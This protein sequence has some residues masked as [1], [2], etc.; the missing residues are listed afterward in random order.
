MAIIAQTAQVTVEAWQTSSDSKGGYYTVKVSRRGDYF[1]GGAVWRNSTTRDRGACHVEIEGKNVV[2]WA[3]PHISAWKW[4]GSVYY[5]RD[6]TS[7]QNKVLDWMFWA[8]QPGWDTF[9]YREFP[10]NRVDINRGTSRQ[11]S[12]SVSAG[13]VMENG[14]SS[15]MGSITIYTS[16]IAD[17]SNVGLSA[18]VSSKTE[19]KRKITV[20]CSFSNPESY[21]TAYLYHGN[22]LLGSSSSG[23]TKTIDVTYSMFNTT[24]TFKLI[25]KGKDGVEYITPKTTSV[26]IEPSGVGIWVRNGGATK[27]VFHVYYKS[28]TGAIVE[29]SEAWYRR[30]NIN[31][32]TVK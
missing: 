16:K 11:A 24:Q 1:W 23:F 22:T 6:Y 5:L 2:N 12:K 7:G 25:I 3:A 10:N 4:D 14:W 21:Y 20:S 15:A 13:V 19:A 31:I 8:P 18:S 28:K 17:P 27:E 9:N 26:Y 32:K 30:N 29:V